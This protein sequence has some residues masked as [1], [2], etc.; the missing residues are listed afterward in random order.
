M[1]IDRV[2]RRKEGE[3]KSIL[4]VSSNGDIGLTGSTEAPLRSRDGGDRC[5][6]FFWPLAH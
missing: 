4:L 3:G 6:Y 2:N 5:R 1:K